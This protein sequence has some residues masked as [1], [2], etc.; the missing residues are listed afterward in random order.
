[1]A[2]ERC[3]EAHNTLQTIAPGHGLILQ[4]Q[5]LQAQLRGSGHPNRGRG[6]L[7]KIQEPQLPR[8]PQTP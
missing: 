6:H 2:D 8:K 7:D 3:V 1:M 4:G 5:H